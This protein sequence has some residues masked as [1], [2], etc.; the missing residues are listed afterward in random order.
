MI[1]VLISKDAGETWE[2]TILPEGWFSKR[3]LE[4][5][6]WEGKILKWSKMIW[7]KL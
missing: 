3:N 7:Y 6:L 4:N 1:R 2:E 5:V